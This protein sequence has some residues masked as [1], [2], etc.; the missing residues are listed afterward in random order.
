MKTRT[1]QHRLKHKAARLRVKGSYVHTNPVTIYC[2]S[3]DFNGIRV[4]ST[5][6]FRGRLKKP[7]EYFDFVI[8]CLTFYKWMDVH[9]Q[10]LTAEKVD[11]LISMPVVETVEYTVTLEEFYHQFKRM[12]DDFQIYR[13]K[14]HRAKLNA[15]FAGQMKAAA[16][17]IGWTECDAVPKGGS[18]SFPTGD[19]IGFDDGPFRRS[20]QWGE[21]MAQYELLR[22]SMAEQM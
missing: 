12:V 2:G 17:K 3:I 1:Q 22:S 7:T 5:V 8:S 6:H 13:D 19:L 14:K 15:K 4:E 10:D 21:M 20:G 9:E 11:E 16:E 18:G